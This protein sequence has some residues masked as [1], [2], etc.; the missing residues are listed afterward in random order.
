MLESLY[1]DIDVFILD[2]GIFDAVVWNEWLKKTGKISSD[3]ATHVE[4]FFTM[5]RWTELVDIIFILTCEPRVSIEREYADQLTTKRGTIMAEGTLRQ[6]LDCVQITM[7]NHGTQFKKIVGIDTSATRTREGVLKITDEALKA[8]NGFVD[9][10]I[11]VVPAAGLTLADKGFFDDPNVISNFLAKVS[12]EKQFIPRSQ[13]ENNPNFVQPIPC[14]ILRYDDNILVLRRKKV[15]QHIAETDDGP[16][17][18]I[19]ALNRELTEE[20]FIKEAFDLNP[21]PIGLL[22]TNEDARASRHIGVLFEVKL[23]S[24]DVALALNQKEFR[25]TRGSSMSGRLVEAKQLEEIYAEMGD[26]SKFIVDHFWS[27]YSP[28]SRRPPSLFDGAE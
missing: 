6:F 8:L 28:K 21:V 1:K 11:C 17:I 10:S 9:E 14:A 15:G 22:R 4:Q 13:A 25:A 2:R 26:W 23:A 24:E 19:N 7:Q 3:E 16:N 5:K 18:I 20:L 27:S 12:R